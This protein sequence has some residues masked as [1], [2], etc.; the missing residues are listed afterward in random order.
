[1]K[2]QYKGVTRDWQKVTGTIEAVDEIEAKLKLR[3][4][5]IR[6]ESLQKGGGIQLSVK[7]D[8]S[9]GSPLNLKGLVIFTRQFSSL[10]DSGV[11]IV[12]I[13]DILHKQE[14]N[15]AF[16]KVLGQIKSDIEGGSGLAEA[17]ARHPRVFNEFFIRVVEAGEISGTLDKALKNVG[18]QL[19]KLGMLKRRVVKA[20]TYPCI[21]L[22]VS[23]VVLIFLLVKVIP[24]VAK[25]YGNN[26]LPELTQLVLS[27]SKI[28]QDNIILI[29]FFL[30][31]LPIATV[32]LIKVKAVRQVLD[33]LLLRVPLFGTLIIRSAVARFSRTLSTLIGSGVPLLTGFEICG[34]IIT[35]YA[36]QNTIKKAAAGVSEGKSI[37]AGLSEDPY[38]P[39]MVLHMITIGEVT[40]RL[41]ELL[42]KV[43]E[44]YD[45]EV[46]SAVDAMTQLLQPLLI[47]G[48][49]IIILFLM[50]AMYMPI[51]N[52][53]EK[54]SGV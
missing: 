44:I 52:L 26:K 37:S 11:P 39:P 17:L 45:D 16:K 31:G 15:K 42:H 13:L 2:Y 43:A 54:I 28:V 20:L 50:M 9:L 8:F 4:M 41:D 18:L 30:F 25:L 21:T 53:G 49:G 48:V 47:V 46:D 3:S 1:M 19:E 24:E 22:V 14:K 6:P 35:N 12:Q 38:F 27:I 5:Q 40:G 10:I 34:K 23:V 36:L 32:F 29:L 51:F 33:P 7:F